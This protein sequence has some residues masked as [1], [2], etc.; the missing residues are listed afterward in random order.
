MIAEGL[1]KSLSDLALNGFLEFYDIE[2]DYLKIKLEQ[3]PRVCFE[4]Q[5]KRLFCLNA[6]GGINE[7]NLFSQIN[8]WR[9]FHST[10]L[11]NAFVPTSIR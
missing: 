1:V 8:F 10:F 3:C 5:S 4:I 7:I 2:K 11:P 6:K 9:K